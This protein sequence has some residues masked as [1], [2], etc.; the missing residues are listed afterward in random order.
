MAELEDARL[1]QLLDKVTQ[2]QRDLE[3]LRK[4]VLILL[5]IALLPILLALLQVSTVLF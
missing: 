1:E 2:M 5:T 4:M 3:G